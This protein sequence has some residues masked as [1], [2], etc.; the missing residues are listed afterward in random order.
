MV[1]FIK[2]TIIQWYIVLNSQKYEQIFTARHTHNGNTSLQK[3]VT[4]RWQSLHSQTTLRF[5]GSLLCRGSEK[6]VKKKKKGKKLETPDP[7]KAEI[8]STITKA[9]KEKWA[10]ISGLLQTI[11]GSEPGV[12][13]R[14]QPQHLTHQSQP[15]L[16][17]TG[18]MM[19]LA[20][21]GP[22]TRQL[23]LGFWASSSLPFCGGC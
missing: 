20:E 19:R 9:F 8:Y 7:S 12:W 22:G 13:G 23:F 10:H 5:I 1:C 11:P 14:E 17:Y 4:Y 6:G 15:R 21:A 2:V 18:P 3:Q 16:V